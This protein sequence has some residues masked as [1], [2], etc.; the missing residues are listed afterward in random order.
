[1]ILYEFNSGGG[2]GHGG[3]GGGGGWQSGGGG[4]GGWQ[5]SGGGHQ[6]TKIIKVIEKQGKFSCGT[7]YFQ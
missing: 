5:S 4:G 1:M 6:P 2:G 3:G 7:F